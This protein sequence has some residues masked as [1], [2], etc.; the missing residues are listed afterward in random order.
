MNT[1][2][3]IQVDP[4]NIFEEHIC[5]AISDKKGENCV[6]SKKEWM[7]NRFSE[8]YV[9]KKLNDRG[10]VFIEYTSG[11]N[12]FAPIDAPDYMVIQCFWVSG[13]FKGQGYANQLLNHCIQDAKQQGLK[14]IA[15]LSSDKKRTFL[16]DPQYLKYKG[17]QVADTAEP[18]F[19]LLYLPFEPNAPKPSFKPIAKTGT[20]T[21]DGVVLYYSNGCPH[22]DKY[23]PIVESVAIE[24]NIPFTA[25]K[26]ETLAQAQSSPTPF[27]IYSLYINGKFHTNEILTDKKFLKIMQQEGIL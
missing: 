11:A 15:A 2:N 6:G 12:V 18:Y 20:I 24:N 4:T 21:Q 19:E 27:T 1:T 26:I 3:I 9:F 25:I 22:T 13:K 14:R 10:K 23:V 5:C 17:F 7:S 8:G 16:T